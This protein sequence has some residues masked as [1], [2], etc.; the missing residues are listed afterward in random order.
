MPEVQEMSVRVTMTLRKYIH[1]EA[2]PFEVIQSTEQVV[3]LSSLPVEVQ[4]QVMEAHNG[5]NDE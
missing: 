4:Q 2:K 3:P 1:G 5:G